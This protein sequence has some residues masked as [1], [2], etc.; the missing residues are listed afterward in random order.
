MHVTVHV[1]FF[2][3]VFMYAYLITESQLGILYPTIR[4]K[5][6]VALSSLQPMDYSPH[7]ILKPWIKVISSCHIQYCTLLVL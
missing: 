4:R 6:G 3:H 1:F 5:L 7:V 2:F